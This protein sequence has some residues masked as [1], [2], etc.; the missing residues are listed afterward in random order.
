MGKRLILD[1]NRRSRCRRQTRT[2]G[3]VLAI[4]VVLGARPGAGEIDRAAPRLARDVPLLKLG[5]LAAPA[6]PARSSKPRTI[7]VVS[8]YVDTL[9]QSENRLA[10]L[11]GPTWCP[12]AEILDL[13][14][15]RRV[16]V[17]SRRGLACGGHIGDLNIWSYG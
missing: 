9:A 17:S 11:Q 7:A 16:R 1:I 4:A 6:T 12:K 2:A 15:R 5:S 10:W 13:R 14:T 3:L 8:D